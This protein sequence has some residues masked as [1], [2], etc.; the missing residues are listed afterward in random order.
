[1]IE[2]YQLPTAGD[3][4]L[5][6]VSLI[7]DL[8]PF[9]VVANTIGESEDELRARADDGRWELYETHEIDCDPLSL[10]AVRARFGDVY[11]GDRID[12]PGA[13]IK[14][15]WGAQRVLPNAAEFAASFVPRGIL[16]GEEVKATERL[17]GRTVNP[18]APDTDENDILLRTEQKLL[19][20]ANVAPDY[21]V[22]DT[23][24]G[25]QAR[26]YAYQRLR[27]PQQPVAK[28]KAQE[29]LLQ[30]RGLDAREINVAL[31]AANRQIPIAEVMNPYRFHGLS[32][33]AA[34]RLSEVRRPSWRSSY[35]SAQ[36]LAGLALQGDINTQVAT[37][38][39]LGGD[40]LVD[41]LSGQV[42]MERAIKSECLAFSRHLISIGM[43]GSLMVSIS[44]DLSG[45]HESYFLD[46]SA[47]ENLAIP[48][49]ALA[50]LGSLAA[51]AI[52]EP[53]LRNLLSY[54]TAGMVLADYRIATD[55]TIAN[56]A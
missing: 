31:D 39:F 6:D 33:D 22:S 51:F 20:L 52:H 21:A 1:M 34:G 54:H 3:V 5:A 27:K 44:E 15:V 55:L 56:K 13:F 8:A 14:A 16:K 40:N 48:G 36:H 28:L 53:P 17:T 12:E 37:R 42:E 25:N 23:E 19:F 9:K 11:R 38:Q 18:D 7:R 24:L 45:P 10:R 29:L 50:R 43:A 26:E 30:A 32:P 41:M 47:N 2:R 46:S 49:E 4:G 35:Q